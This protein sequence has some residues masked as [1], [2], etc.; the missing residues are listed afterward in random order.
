MATQPNMKLS[1]IAC[2]VLFSLG[3]L[4]REAC[5]LLQ[6]ICMGLRAPKSSG[7]KLGECLKSSARAHQASSYNKIHT[8]YSMDVV[9]E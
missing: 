3:Q 8:R 1:Y 9:L 4:L 6:E 2:D 7:N 5:V